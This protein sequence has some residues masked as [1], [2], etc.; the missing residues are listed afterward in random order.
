MSKVTHWIAN[1]FLFSLMKFQIFKIYFKCFYVDLKGP[2]ISWYL[3]YQQIII[4]WNYN[5]M[6]I[7]LNKTNKQNGDDT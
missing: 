2:I 7:Q 6:S 5:N 3:F 1:I 4:R